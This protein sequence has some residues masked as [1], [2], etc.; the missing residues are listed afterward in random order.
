MAASDGGVVG[1]LIAWLAGSIPATFVTLVDVRLERAALAEALGVGFSLPADAPL[2]QD[3]V[4]HTSATSAGLATALSLA[5]DEAVVLE[6]SWYGATPVQAPLGGAFHHRRLQLRSS[7]VGGIPTA[8]RPRWGY[9][10][11]LDTAL[12][13]LADPRLDALLEP[14]IPFSELPRRMPAVLADGAGGLCHPIVY[15]ESP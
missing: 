9:H 3:V 11:R 1:A 2:E 8:R 6:V 14:D 7:Q 10:R 12:R 15:P 5:G 13:L 4:V